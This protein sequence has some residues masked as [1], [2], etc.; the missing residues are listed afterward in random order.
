MED[1]KAIA[2]VLRFEGVC[3]IG[4]AVAMY[5]VWSRK[6]RAYLQFRGAV[7]GDRGGGGL[8]SVV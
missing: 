8:D 3:V 1:Q 2:A 5:G 7:V 6:R 4:A